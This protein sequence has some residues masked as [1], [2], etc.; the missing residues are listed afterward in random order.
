MDQREAS[1]ETVPPTSISWRGRR[2]ESL[3]RQELL[4]AICQLVGRDWPHIEASANAASRN[5]FMGLATGLCASAVL[6]LI[7]LLV[8]A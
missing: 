2:L 4:Q 6:S 5:F 8:L 7:A 3:D 1:F